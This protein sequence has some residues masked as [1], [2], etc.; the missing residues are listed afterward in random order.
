MT[1]RGASFRTVRTA[2][3][4]VEQDGMDDEEEWDE[5]LDGFLYLDPKVGDEEL[6]GDVGKKQASRRRRASY[7][8]VVVFVCGEEVC[9]RC[10]AWLMRCR[11]WERK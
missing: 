5:V 11:K 3:R 10:N 1:A 9:W 7:E 6:D 8:D 2:C 4:F